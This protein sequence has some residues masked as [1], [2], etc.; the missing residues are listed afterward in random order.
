MFKHCI[1]VIQD[2]VMS[3]KRNYK[4]IIVWSILLV[5]L[6]GS[7]TVWYLFNQKHENTAEIKPD[8]TVEALPFIQEFKQDLAS[9]NKK[10]SEKIVLVKGNVAEIEK[11]DSTVNLKMVDTVTGSYVIFAFQPQDA[12]KVKQVKQGDL[13]SIKGSCS[14]GTYSKIL[15]TNSITFKRCS[16]SN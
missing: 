2:N 13:V 1:F 12:E 11:A 9:A 15:E 8:F 14:N 5:L 6:A 3:T 7:A 10:Y 16:I 4:K